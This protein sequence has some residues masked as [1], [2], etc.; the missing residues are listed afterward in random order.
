[1]KS[2]SEKLS[3][4]PSKNDFLKENDIQNSKKWNTFL[5]PSN[6]FIT[7]ND[8]EKILKHGNITIEIDDLS[9]W[10]QA[11]IHKSYVYNQTDSDIKNMSKSMPLQKKSNERLEWLGDAKLQ[12]IV[13]YYLYKRYSD[14]D[15]GFL[16]KL[17]SKLV[18]TN[19][20]SFLAK[21][22]GLT[23]YIV[24]SYHVEY[25]CQGR[26]NIRILENTFEAF[27]GS[28]FIYCSEKF[29]ENISNELVGKFIVTVIEKYVDMVEM[30]IKDDNSKDQLMWY[31]QKHFNGLFPIY[32]KEKVENE[33]FYIFIKEPKTDKIIGRGKARSKKK[34]EQNAAKDALLYYSN[35]YVD[36]L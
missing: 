13:S 4:S 17:R 1:M 14:Q 11:F 30:V 16:T 32:L 12:G 18:K 23:P 27:I 9:I 34:A 2:I 33:E 25:S 31:F 15:E 35:I 10:Q 7:K 3:H 28:M 22:I 36:N 29:G 5:N 20:L 21:K 19:N 26:S 8:I 6:V 24:L